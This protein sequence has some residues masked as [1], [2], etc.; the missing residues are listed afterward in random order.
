[1]QGRQVVSAD[2][3]VGKIKTPSRRNT[4]PKH[5]HS[6]ADP[7]PVTLAGLQGNRIAREIA[8]SP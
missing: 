4:R 1:M 6:H 3:A 2:E 7:V 5:N 8:Q